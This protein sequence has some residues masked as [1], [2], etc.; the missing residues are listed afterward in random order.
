MVTQPRVQLHT[1][2]LLLLVV[3]LGQPVCVEVPSA[4][5]A[6]LGKSMLLTC[7]FCMKREELKPKTHVNW[8]YKPT[9]D[10]PTVHIYNYEKRMLSPQAGQF[11]GRLTWKGSYDFQEVSIQI[12]NVTFNDSG[13]YE[14]HVTREFKDF[15]PPSN[16]MKNITLKVKEKATNDAAA[17]Y[18][19]IMM[20][21]LLVCLTLW[22]LVEM[23][24]CYRKITKSDEQAQDTAY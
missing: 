11:K 16:F 5:E 22:L 4:T 15:I 14:C 18:S 7:I 23:V 3:H 10:I 24:Y 6:V 20:Y 21:V 2:A 19:G 1:L 9:N 12:H 13:I 8:Y 17:L